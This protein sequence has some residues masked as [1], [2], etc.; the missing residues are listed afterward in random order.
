MARTKTST[1]KRVLKSLFLPKSVYR[2]WWEPTADSQRTDFAGAWWPCTV[3]EVEEG[4]F[5][6]VQVVYDNGHIEDVNFKLLNPLAAPVAF[7][8][9]ERSKLRVGVYCEIS[10]ASASD[11]CAWVGRIA[12]VSGS[13]YRFEWPFH[14][15]EDDQFYTH[16]RVRRAYVYCYEKKA[17]FLPLSNQGGSKFCSPFEMKRRKLPFN[18][19]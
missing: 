1:V 5:G 3:K 4:M 16:D 11:P 14:D 15:H 19:I 8:E 2:V 12:E 10:N 13:T 6:R 17:W 9:E 18:V 7:G